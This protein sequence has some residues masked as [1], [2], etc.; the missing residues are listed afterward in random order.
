MSQRAAEEALARQR[1]LREQARAGFANRVERLRDQLS[2]EALAARV[3]DDITYKTRGVVGQAIEIASDNRGVLIGTLSALGAALAVWAA[4]KPIG[5]GVL[6]FG[7]KFSGKL[8][9]KLGARL[10]GKVS[11]LFPGS[12]EPPA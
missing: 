11:G 4:R 5:R 8:G 9:G 10:A 12:K 2:P 1:A 7:G 3:L 6:G